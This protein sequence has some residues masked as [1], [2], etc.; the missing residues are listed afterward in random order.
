MK[1]IVARQDKRMWLIL[2]QLSMKAGWWDAPITL[3]DLVEAA[4]IIPKKTLSYSFFWLEEGLLRIFPP[5]V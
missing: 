1:L 2:R 5:L 4:N 3:W